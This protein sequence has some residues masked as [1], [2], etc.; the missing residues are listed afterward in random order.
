MEF[1][2]DLEDILQ[3]TDPFEKINQFRRLYRSY[4]AGSVECIWDSVP[5]IFTAPSFA[6]YCDVVAATKVPRRRALSTKEDRAILLHAIAHIEYSAIDLALDAAYR[7]R[8]LPKKF[9]DDWLGVAD[10]EVRHFLMLDELLKDLGYR[11]GDFSVHS[12]LFDTSMATLDLVDRM[13]CVPRYLEASGLDANP[14]IIKRVEKLNDAFSKKVIGVLQTILDEEVDHVRKGDYWYKYACDKE[15]I[16]PE[17]FFTIVEKYL[18]GA[19]Q[20]KAFVNVAF[21]KQAGYSCNLHSHSTHNEPN[22]K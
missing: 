10:D 18:P 4:Q 11:Y 14:Q 2:T 16:D 17:N 3:T 5:K 7:F 15:G 20:K 13:A 22:I 19:S 12:F 21:R 9:Y 8:H 6:G 1:F